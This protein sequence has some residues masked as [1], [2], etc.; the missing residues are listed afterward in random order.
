LGVSTASPAKFSPFSGRPRPAF[1][2]P[3]TA[4]TGFRPALFASHRRSARARCPRRWSRSP[5]RRPSSPSTPRRARATTRSVLADTLP[6]TFAPSASARALASARVM[7]SSDPVKTTVLPAMGCRWRARSG[8]RMSWS[9]APPAGRSRRV[10]LLPQRVGQRQRDRRAD[11]VDADQVVPGRAR[12]LGTSASSQAALRTSAL[13]ARRP[14]ACARAPPRPA[15]RS[16]RWAAA[17]GMAAIDGLEGRQLVKCA[18]DRGA[19]SPT[20]R[21]PSAKISRQRDAPLFVDRVEQVGR[22]F[23]APALAVLQ[24][25]QPAP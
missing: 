13:R 7:R 24:L 10:A 17:A 5:V 8:G 15:P 22:R 16:A 14:S 21:M 20:W 1:R 25:L 19:T 12:L 23:L 11:A 3:R 2:A 6:E 4:G 9:S 18:R